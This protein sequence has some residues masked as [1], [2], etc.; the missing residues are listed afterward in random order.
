MTSLVKS[1]D[2]NVMNVA[3]PWMGT[4][5]RIQRGMD[6]LFGDWMNDF[7]PWTGGVM[8]AIPVDLTETDDEVRVVA[9][10][11]GLA[12]DQI[13]VSLTGN[14]LTISGE[15]TQE[16]N[17]E[18]KG[19][20]YSERSYGAFRRSIQLPCPVDA[21]HVEAKHEHGLVTITLR[22]AEAARS[23]HIPVKA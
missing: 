12:P 16:Q 15:K 13:D 17:T 5:S 14:V 6:R 3:D 8:P 7:G 9:E 19:M 20:R 2:S 1:N 10:V 4:L 21:D 18:E 22:K 11:P 23:R